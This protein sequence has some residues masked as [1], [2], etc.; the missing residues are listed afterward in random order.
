MPPV[1]LPH[2]TPLSPPDPGLW[3]TT[4]AFMTTL[5]FR[6]APRTVASGYQCFIERV[7]HVTQPLIHADDPHPL[8]PNHQHQPRCGQCWS[9]IAGCDQ[10]CC[11]HKLES[12]HPALS[13]LELASRES[14]IAVETGIIESGMTELSR[15]RHHPIVCQSNGPVVAARRTKLVSLASDDAAYITGRLSR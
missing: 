9:A 5:R 14:P 6:Y 15:Y 4:P 7:F 8:G 2:Y 13:S 10:P 1:R 3:S 12:G 11:S